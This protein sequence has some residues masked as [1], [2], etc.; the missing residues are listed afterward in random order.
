VSDGGLALELDLGA[1]AR[2]H[3]RVVERLPRDCLVICSVKANAYGH[4]VVT[5]VRTLDDLG[6]YAVA[7]ASVAD[8]M[9]LREAGIRARILLFGGQ[10]PEAVR[11]LSARGLTV[12]VAN[13]ETAAALAG[14]NG[15]VFVKIDAGLGRLGIPVEEAAAVLRDAILPAGV[16]VQGIYTHLPFHDADGERWARAR[17]E[18]FGELVRGLHADGIDIPLV[19]ALSSPGISAGLPLEGNAVCPGRLLY[20]LIPAAG[21]AHAWGLEPV[22]RT[23]STRIVHLRRHGDEA[24]VGGGGKYRVGAGTRTAVIPFGRSSGNLADPTLRPAVIHRGRRVPMV[25]I[26]LEHATLA[27]GDVEGEVGDQV[28][29]VGGEGTPVSLDELAAWSHLEPLDALVALDRGSAH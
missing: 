16:D 28:F 22:L 18:R 8:A 3:A 6:V 26:S 20:G 29:I 24:G 25:S 19:Q 5:V 10:P 7:T 11:E 21:S 4:G 23:L 17:L 9:A 12:T 15:P 1:L 13:R 14:S 27:L 2:N